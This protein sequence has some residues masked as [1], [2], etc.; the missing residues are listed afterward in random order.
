MVRLTL[1]QTV[2]NEKE[3]VC[4]TPLNLGASSRLT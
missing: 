3:K 4:L 2:S 1:R